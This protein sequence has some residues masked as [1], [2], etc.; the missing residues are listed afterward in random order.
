MSQ[1][2]FGNID[3]YVVD[4]VELADFLNQ[5]RD[6]LNSLHRGGV[7]PTYVVPG[8]LWI[9]DAAGPSDWVLQWYVSPT[10]GDVALF[11]LNTIT[12]A[13][14]ISASAGGIVSAATLLAEADA[15][16]A[17]RWQA[18]QNPIDA[19]SWRATVTATGALRFGAYNDAGVEVAA[20]EI[21]RDGTIQGGTPP[22]IVFDYAGSVVPTGYLWCAGQ[23]VSRTAYAAL[24]N[25][26][27]IAYGGGDGV[28]TFNV[29]DL[30]GRVGVGK[31]NMNGIAVNRVTNSG[32]GNSGIAG[33]TLGASGGEQTHAMALA[34]NA[35]HGHSIVA[36]I[37]LVVYG[38]TG[39]GVATLAAGGDVP[40][41]TTTL[42]SSGSGTGHQNMP[43]TLILN[44]IIKT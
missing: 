4:G 11:T 42:A 24:F 32:T 38:N 34:E 23:A 22:G 28:L 13:I 18:D 14:T 43:P 44:K 30:R 20:V 27:G 10:V 9:N 6:A 29:P 17:V 2:D 39:A 40:L 31:D 26:I 36:G 16:P 33:V 19:K 7:R 5:W 41:Y 25:A 35:A 3:P 12:G 15:N 21:E 37:G 8:M 1:F